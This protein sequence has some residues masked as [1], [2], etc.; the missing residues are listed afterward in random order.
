MTASKPAAPQ[1]SS[2]H[3]DKRV[4]IAIFVV[5]AL[6]SLSAAF[7]AG[8]INNRTAALEQRLNTAEQRAE[9]LRHES[10]IAVLEAQWEAVNARLDR[11]EGQADAIATAVGAN[12]REA[13][14]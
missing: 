7:W 4:P 6:Q 10:R 9:N 3:L 13:S 5:L 2:W 8:A 12:P 11:I 14:P 1:E